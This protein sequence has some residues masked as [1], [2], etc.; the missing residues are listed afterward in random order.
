[1]P[2]TD[3]AAE[4]KPRRSFF[5]AASLTLL[6]AQPAFVASS[7]VPVKASAKAS[8]L[9]EPARRVRDAARAAGKG[10][11]AAATPIFHPPANLVE[12][13]PRRTNWALFFSHVR[14]V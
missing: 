12:Q 9:P 8:P 13:D 4:P 5:A 7:Y 11:A 3:G 2:S 10:V 14:C 6:T 1:M